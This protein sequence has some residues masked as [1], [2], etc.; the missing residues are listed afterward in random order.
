MCCAPRMKRLVELYRPGCPVE[1]LLQGWDGAA[2]CP[3]RVVAQA[4]PG[5]WVQVEDGG[6]WFVTNGRRIRPRPGT[7]AHDEPG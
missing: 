3:G 7:E 4:H 5:V 2:W 1:I 6:R